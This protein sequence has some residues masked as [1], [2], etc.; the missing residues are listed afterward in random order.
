MVNEFCRKLIKITLIILGICI[1][2]N[3]C[4]F[5]CSNNNA[6]T[7]NTL[8]TYENKKNDLPEKNKVKFVV[9]HMDGCG[10]CHNI[11]G[12]KQSNNMTIFEQVQKEFENDNNVCVF[13]FKYGRDNEASKF[14]AFPVIKII[15]ENGEQEYNQSRTAENMINAIN[16]AK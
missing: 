16:R 1:I 7:N 12:N 3:I 15:T 9:Y 10:H 6:D 14:N 8:E 11:M 2:V 4:N 13:D 5:S